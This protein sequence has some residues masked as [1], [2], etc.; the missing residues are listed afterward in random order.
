[1]AQSFNYQKDYESILKRTQTKG[2]SFE[3]KHLL[4]KFLKNDK[5]LTVAETLSLMIGYTGLPNYRPFDDVKTEHLILHLNDSAR[6]K[7]AIR[8]CDTFLKNHPLNQAAIIEKAYAYYQLKQQDS[9]SY[10]K[11]QFGRIMAAMDWSAD[12]RTPDNAMFAIG[13]EDGKNFADKYYHSDVGNTTT[14]INKYGDYC[15]AVQMKYKKD[16]KMNE[17]VFYFALQHAANTTSKKD[18]SK[19]KEK[20]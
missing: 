5:T 1:M 12:G 8:M 3:Y 17:I 11:Q 2:D 4:P 13:P 19:I 20:P 14:V 6:Y 15:S 16:G 9:A 18:T 7:E 10:Y